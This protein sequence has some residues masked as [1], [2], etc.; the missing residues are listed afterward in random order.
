MIIVPQCSPRSRLGLL[1]EALLL[2]FALLAPGCAE[3]GPVDPDAA[4][5]AAY[6][7]W[8]PWADDYAVPTGTAPSSTRHTPRLLGTVEGAPNGYWEYL[9]PGY[10][11]RPPSPLL[12]FWHGMGEWGS[13]ADEESLARVCVAGPPLLIEQDSWPNALPFVVL[14]PQHTEFNCPPADEIRDFLAFAL[15][16][17]DVDPDRVYLTGLSCGAIG[18]WNYLAEDLDAVVDG[19]VLIAGDG[20]AAW[21]RA[22][23]DLGRV[24]IWAFHGSE[25]Q[26]VSLAGSVEPIGA[27]QSCT[28]PPPFDARLT[29]Y[30][31]A[32][33]TVWT[34]TYDLSAW[35]DVYTWLLNG[36]ITPAPVDWLEDDWSCVGMLDWPTAPSETFDIW[37]LYATVTP[38]L[39]WGPPP[40]GLTVDVCSREDVECTTPLDT[41]VVDSTRWVTWYPQPIPKA[42]MLTLTIP[43]PG[44]GFDGF[45]RTTSD[46]TVPNYIWLLPP[47]HEGYIHMGCCSHPW[48]GPR[49]IVSPEALAAAAELVDIAIDPTKGHVLVH[50]SSCGYLWPEEDCCYDTTDIGVTLDGRPPDLPLP[51][52]TSSLG[53]LNSADTLPLVFFNVDPGPV[54]L[55]AGFPSQWGGG[56][57]G[58][59]ERVVFAGALTQVIIGP[60]PLE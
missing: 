58:R 4:W 26:N 43:T 57:V 20:R 44:T 18:S 12:V 51:G 27:L 38:S 41:G 48:F 34:R 36:G 56:V 50:A 9:P 19:A 35:H 8:V 32:G 42:G 46:D 59:V 28:D 33:H 16:A 30:E 45:F 17:Y 2:A 23:C 25:D 37:L 15:E 47:A 54:T 3:D 31:G 11:E 1:G 40:L 55:E 5:Q 39:E 10:G 49:R 14:S 60:T 24:R 53:P 22:G 6:G 29:V 7:D 21:D 52:G 13:G